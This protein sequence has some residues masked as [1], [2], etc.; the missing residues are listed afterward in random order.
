MTT[1]QAPAT[2]STLSI[3]ASAVQRIINGALDDPMGAP[4]GLGDGH[5]AWATRRALAAH[6]WTVTEYNEAINARL[7][8]TYLAFCMTLDEE[9]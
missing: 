5:T 6:G 8:N 4:D 2:R 9:A 7:G 1:T 3:A